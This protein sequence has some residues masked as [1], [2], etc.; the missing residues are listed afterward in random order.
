MLSLISTTS[1][2]APGMHSPALMQQAK[3]MAVF[4]ATPNAAPVYD[5]Q[6]AEELRATATAMVSSVCA[7]EFQNQQAHKPHVARV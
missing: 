3:P 7:E 5:G 1:S 2:F 6:Y 4:M